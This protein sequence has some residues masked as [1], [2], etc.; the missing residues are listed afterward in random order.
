MSRGE[1]GEIDQRDAPIAPAGACVYRGLG[2]G[3]VHRRTNPSPT[4]AET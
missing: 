3:A 2:V 4:A 1:A